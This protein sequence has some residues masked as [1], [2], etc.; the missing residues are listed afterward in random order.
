MRTEAVSAS[1]AERIGAVN[2]AVNGFVWGPVMLA[3]F[4]AVGLLFT[5]RTGLFQVTHFRMWIQATLFAIFKRRDVR[6]TDDKYAI[7]RFQSLCTAL[8]ATVGTGSIVGV[9]TAIALG[10]PGAVFWMWVSAFLGMMT[11][12]AE[13]ALG[14]K[15]RFKN[16]KGEWAGGAMYYMER[17]LNM[18]RLGALFALFCVFASFGIGNM[19]QGNSIAE[20]IQSA[21]FEKYAQTYVFGGITVVKA[22]VGVI[23]M[24]FTA[25]VILGGIKRI[26]AVTEKFVPFMVILYLIGGFVV[27]FANIGSAGSVLKLIFGEAFKAR[28]AAGGFAG[29]GIA[30]AMRFGIS[31]GVFSN[32]AGLGSSVMAHSASDVREP[33]EQGMWAIFEVFLDTIVV[34]A[35]TALAILMSGAYDVERHLTALSVSAELPSSMT[36]IELTQAAFATVFG[37]FG[38]P[39]ISVAVLMFALATILGWSYYGEKAWRYIFGA[40]SAI[41]YKL[42]FIVVIFF[43][44]VSELSLVWDISDTFNGLMAIPNLIAIIL[45]NSEV[46]TLTKDYLARLK[47]IARR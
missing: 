20:G 40:E 47:R 44:C 26:A 30:S 13:N 7:S 22:T 42:I 16:E 28:S 39:F 25:P 10:G 29:Y 41:V 2:S 21:F 38:A 46:V 5:L 1:A 23:I 15:Y 31:R 19:T 37:R 3:L 8:A 35:I 32:E 6:K 43:G 45:L 27:I 11:N 34:C 17:G 36:G 14:I 9:A 4:I 12:Y 24:L 33:V 18:K